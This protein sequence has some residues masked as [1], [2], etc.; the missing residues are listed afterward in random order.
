M[1]EA[2]E[3]K[4]SWCDGRVVSGGGKGHAEALCPLYVDHISIILLKSYQLILT[5][6]DQPTYYHF[7]IHVVHVMLESGITQAT[8][9]AFGL[10]NLISQL[11]T[12]VGGPEAGMADVSLTYY[13]GE[14]NELW[15]SIFSPLKEAGKK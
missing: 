10:E 12:L 15:T 11:E 9:K 5:S 2:Y 6:L 8:G 7:H 4:D 1:V 3:G 14:A 13:V